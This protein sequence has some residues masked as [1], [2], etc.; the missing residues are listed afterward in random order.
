MKEKEDNKFILGVGVFEKGDSWA[1][2]RLEEQQTVKKVLKEEKRLLDEQENQNGK[3]KEEIEKQQA[4]R[5]PTRESYHNNHKCSHI[6][7][8]YNNHFLTSSSY[9]HVCNNIYFAFRKCSQP[10]SV[11]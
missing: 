8:Y 10:L 1:K 2:W 3:L 5:C 4:D 6:V 9:Y 7:V 11:F